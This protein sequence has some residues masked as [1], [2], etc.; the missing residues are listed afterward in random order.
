MS[1]IC[2][3]LLISIN[4]T[5]RITQGLKKTVWQLMETR[6]NDEQETTDPPV[7]CV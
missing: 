3:C 1:S 6:L 7:A 4:T 5:I 2:T